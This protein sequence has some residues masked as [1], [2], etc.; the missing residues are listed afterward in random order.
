MKNVEQAKY[1]YLINWDDYLA[2]KALYELLDAQI[3]VRIFHEAFSHKIGGK[4]VSFDKGTLLV[5]VENQALSSDKI[6]AVI[7]GSKSK[8]FDLIFIFL[9]TSDFTTL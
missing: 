3:R 4:S 5:P 8:P 7:S 6:F 2:P 1:G 9:I